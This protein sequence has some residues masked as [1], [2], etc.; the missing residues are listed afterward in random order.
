VGVIEPSSWKLYL[1]VVLITGIGVGVDL[2][3]PQIELADI[4]DDN[5]D[6]RLSQTF[7]ALFSIIRKAAIGIAAGI[8]LTGYGLLQNHEISMFFNIAP[9]KIFYFFIPFCLKFLVLFMVIRYRN[10]FH[11]SPRR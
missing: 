5:S 2:I 6:N 11:V 9:I 7:T 8:A 3:I 4:L 10:R 1:I